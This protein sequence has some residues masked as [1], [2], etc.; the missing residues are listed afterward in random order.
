M[1]SLRVRLRAWHQLWDTD[2]VRPLSMTACR[3]RGR[4]PSVTAPPLAAAQFR[5]DRVSLAPVKDA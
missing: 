5:L 1:C 3:R 2:V 4:T